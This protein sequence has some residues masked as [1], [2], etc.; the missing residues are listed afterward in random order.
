MKRIFNLK[1]IVIWGAA[2]WVLLLTGCSL[3]RSAPPATPALPTHWVSDVTSSSSEQGSA[4][5]F[6]ASLGDPD[7]PTILA[8]ALEKNSDLE[9][10]RLQMKLTQFQAAQGRLSLFPDVSLGANAT[11]SRPLTSIDGLSPSTSR[12]AG[13]N[14]SLSY[15]LDIWGYQLAQ[16][17]AGDIDAQASEDDWQAARLALSASVTQA[18]WQLG[19]QNRVVA[20]AQSDLENA[21]ETLRLAQVRYQAGATARGDVIFAQQALANQQ[22]ALSQ[23]QQ[24]LTEAR[25][26]FAILMGDPPGVRYAELQDLSD[27]PLPVPDAGLPADLLS[28]RPDVHAAELR[29]RSSLAN[30]DATRLSFYPTLTLTS[31]LG[32]SSPTLGNY[33]TNPMGSLATILALPFIQFNT[34]D[35]TNKSAQVR[36]EMAVINFKK[37]LYIALQETENALSA[38]QQLTQQAQYL[39]DMLAQSREAER[40]TQVRWQQGSTDIQPWLDAQQSRRQAELSL[41]QNTLARKNN[42][43]QLYAALGGSYQQDCH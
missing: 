41:L 38:R 20:N 12:S 22:N 39:R 17:E 34:A 27:T 35:I 11:V 7:L 36:Y 33:L 23:S 6:W 2:G 30:V 21:K 29:V 5:S 43:V 18:R 26:A 15:P 9:L 1:L 31:S 19:Y 24:Q 32:T 4:K 16:R 8:Q 42:A 3:L 14:A 25:F 40:L 37:S 10:S 13:M 28:R